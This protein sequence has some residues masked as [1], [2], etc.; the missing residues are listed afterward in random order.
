MAAPRA[1]AARGEAPLV[2]ALTA[3]LTIVSLMPVSTD[4]SRL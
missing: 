4:V 2:L 3:L 1:S